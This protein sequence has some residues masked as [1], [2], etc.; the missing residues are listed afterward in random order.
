V[1]PFLLNAQLAVNKM[2][3]NISWLEQCVKLPVLLENSQ[4]SHLIHVKPA[5]LV[6]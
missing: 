6:V 4:S 1:G 2:E 3:L 5:M